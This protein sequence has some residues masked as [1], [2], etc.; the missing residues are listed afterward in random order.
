MPPGT[1][2]VR[3]RREPRWWGEVEGPRPTT[4]ELRVPQEALSA[5]SSI[6][7]LV[8]SEESSVPVNFS[9]TVCPA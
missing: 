3:N 7:K 1:V 6:T 2:P 4:A 8:W 9:V 5:V